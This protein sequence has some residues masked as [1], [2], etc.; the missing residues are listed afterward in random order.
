MRLIRTVDQ[1]LPSPKDPHTNE[2]KTC[3][4]YSVPYSNCEYVDI[5]KTELDLKSRLA[6]HIRAIGDLRSEQSALCP[7]GMQLQ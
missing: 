1:V 2:E 3:V 5:E 6:E 7:H 4:I